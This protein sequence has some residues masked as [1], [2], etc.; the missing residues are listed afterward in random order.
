MV[1]DALIA[2]GLDA[3]I[4]GGYLSG[5][6]GE[7]PPS[8]LVSVWIAD[9]EGV[10]QARQIIDAIEQD[11][12]QRHKRCDAV[13]SCSHCQEVSSANFTHC[14]HCGSRLPDPLLGQ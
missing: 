7:L 3:H 12:S 5:A 1:A 11:L 6:I 10:D 9:N 13:L 2:A 8:T 4:Q 14:W